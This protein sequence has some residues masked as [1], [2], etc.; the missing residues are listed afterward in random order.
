MLCTLDDF[1]GIANLFDGLPHMIGAISNLSG[2][3]I[4][5]A[6]VSIKSENMRRQR[7][8]NETGVNNINNYTKLVKTSEAELPVPHLFIQVGNDEV[9]ELFQSGWSGAEY[10]NDN[11][12]GE[13]SRMGILSDTGM[14]IM[15]KKKTARVSSPANSV[16]QLDAVKD[17]LADIAIHNGYTR[18]YSLWKE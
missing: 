1:R 15:G 2:S 8:F 13:D 7:V 3:A 9:Y 17:Y 14:K 11:C 5:R 16:T 6:M 18:D 12:A 4:K 10:K